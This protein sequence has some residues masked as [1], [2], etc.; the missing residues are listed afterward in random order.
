MDKKGVSAVVIAQQFGMAAGG[1]VDFNVMMDDELPDVPISR[2]ELD[3]K[4]K[5]FTVDSFL[6]LSCSSHR[7]SFSPRVDASLLLTVQSVLPVE[8]HCKVN[9]WNNLGWG[10][11]TC[12][13]CRLCEAPSS[14][15]D[16]KRQ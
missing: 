1:Y 8:T 11:N 15:G 12:P 4:K 14:F 6:V 7:G 16:R 13:Y 10:P 5:Y 3:K 9:H 2:Y